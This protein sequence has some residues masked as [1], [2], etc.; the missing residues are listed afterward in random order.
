MVFNLLD[1]FLI[2]ISQFKE[3][4]SKEYDVNRMND[5]WWNEHWRI[6]PRI[7]KLSDKLKYMIE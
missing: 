5:H 1:L 3:I 4:S 6:H 2:S 7:Y